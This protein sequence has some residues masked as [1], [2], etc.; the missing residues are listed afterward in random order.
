MGAQSVLGTRVEVYN[1]AKISIGSNVVVSQGSYLCSAS[2]DYTDP[3]F[4]LFFRP[5]VIEDSAWIASNAFV[6]PGVSIGKGAVIGAC[7]VVV[8]D[9]PAWMV[10]AGNPCQPVKRREMRGGSSPR[11]MTP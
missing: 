4:P 8:K 10:C 11:V 1:L 7:A 6:G 5:I 9:M 2:H 3:A